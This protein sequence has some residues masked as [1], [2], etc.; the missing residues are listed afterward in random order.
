MIEILPESQDNVLAVKGSGRLTRRDYQ[1]FLI[2]SLEAILKDYGKAR[3]LFYMDS[4]FKG[5][6]VSAAWDYAKLGFKHRDKFEKVAGVCGPKWVHWGMK[7]TSYLV[8]GE[9][10]TFEC[11]QHPG[12]AEWIAS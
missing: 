8:N 12:A 9:V 5:W 11:D 7:L 6:D 10:K 2:P 1:E 3:F 4:G